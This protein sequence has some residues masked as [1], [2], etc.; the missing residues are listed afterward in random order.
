MKQIGSMQGWT[1]VT[2]CDVEAT[3][4]CASERD[5]CCSSFDV[6]R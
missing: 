4:F 2:D 1:G 6:K 5:R 3:I